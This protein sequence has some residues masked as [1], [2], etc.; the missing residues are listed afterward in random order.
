V[1]GYV[2]PGSSQPSLAASASSSGVVVV[3]SVL[4]LARLAVTGIIAF[5]D[6]GAV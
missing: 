2:R 1:H 6:G 4:P 3:L 5:A